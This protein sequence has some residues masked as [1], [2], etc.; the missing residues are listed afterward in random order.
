M[1]SAKPDNIETASG[2]KTMPMLLTDGKDYRCSEC[3]Q[4][5]TDDAKGCPICKA[6]FNGTATM[7]KKSE[8]IP[9]SQEY[10]DLLEQRYQKLREEMGEE[11]FNRFLETKRLMK[12]NYVKKKAK[13]EKKNSSS[14]PAIVWILLA[15]AISIMI[16][17]LL[18]KIFP[19]AM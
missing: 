12:E 2:N 7:V 13:I 9:G 18:A 10:M 17:F 15:A 1:L 3:G 14:V 19:G 5:L 11:H 6:V 8:I 16:Y 4:R